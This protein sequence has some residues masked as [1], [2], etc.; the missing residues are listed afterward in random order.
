MTMLVKWDGQGR[1]S[2]IGWPFTDGRAHPRSRRVPSS[3]CNVGIVGA[4]PSTQKSKSRNVTM[5]LSAYRT[6]R[7]TSSRPGFSSSRR[8]CQEDGGGGPSSLQRPGDPAPEPGEGPEGGC[9]AWLGVFFIISM[10]ID[11][12]SPKSPPEIVIKIGMCVGW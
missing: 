2:A 10:V 11:T 4:S 3:T 8:H 12:A 5:S 7:K 9:E 1:P 6:C